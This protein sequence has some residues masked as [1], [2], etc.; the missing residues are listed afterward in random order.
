MPPVASSSRIFDIAI[1]QL[2]SISANPVFTNNTCALCQT[3]LEVAKFLS[4]TA[5]EHG[6]EFFAHFCNTFKLSS[7]C[8]V[9]YSLSGIG[10]VI[11]Q[12]I[13]NADVG[14]YDGQASIK[15]LPVCLISI[16]S[17][18]GHL[19]QLRWR[20]PATPSCTTQFDQL[21]RKAEAQPSPSS[22]ATQWKEGSC[23][24]PV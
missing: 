10:S 13:A 3:S 14:G 22:E 2:Q 20:V 1:A 21:V 15:F 8:N 17:R 4:L 16:Y 12:V 5:P 23:F 19:S 18:L 9:T 7:T 6:P 11:T 24:T